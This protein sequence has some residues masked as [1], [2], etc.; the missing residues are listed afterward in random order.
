MLTGFARENRARRPVAQRLMRTLV[1]VERKPPADAP[2]SLQH[3]AIRLDEHVLIFQA[4]S[5]P[6]DEDVVQKPPSAV[7]TDPH[8]RG[9]KLVQ[10]RRTGELYTLIGVENFRPAM[11]GHRFLNRL[12]AE[13]RFHRD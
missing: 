12:D 6:L 11:F 13:V 7:H 2:A 5:E 1:V 8:A 10:K 3:R 9:L 4:A